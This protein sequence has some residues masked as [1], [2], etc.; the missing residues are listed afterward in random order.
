MAIVLLTGFD[1]FAGD[2]TN[3][4]GDAVRAVAAQWSGPDELVAE[5]LPVAFTSSAVRL[6]ELISR[7]SP[8]VVISVG[9]AGGRSAVSVERVA[10]NL[11]DAR[12][13][14]N[15]GAQPIDV[16]SVPGAAAAGFA[17]LPVK[18]VAAAISAA[19]IPA[20]V[21][22]T[23]GTFVCNHVFATGL[24]AAPHARVGFIHVPWDTEH[25]PEDTPSLPAA[26]LVRAVRIAVD[27]ALAGGPDLSTS[28]GTL[29]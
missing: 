4:S 2:A 20:A 15:D 26:D 9:L 28:A 16:P 24:D 13:P 11:Q 10:V 6:R 27:T 7:H 22:L 8:D 19:D 17:T 12:I 5:I 1:P 3:P 18:A 14:D 25:A 29:H 23:A 21:S